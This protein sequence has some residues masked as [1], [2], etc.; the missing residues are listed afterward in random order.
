MTEISAFLGTYLG[1][2]I[3]ITAISLLF[4]WFFI[5]SAV[6]SGVEAALTYIINNTEYIEEITE[7]IRKKEYDEEIKN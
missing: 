5:R 2:V 3:F 1:A 4:K 7:E 6:R